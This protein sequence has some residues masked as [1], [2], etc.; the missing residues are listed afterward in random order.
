M[1]KTMMTL[2]FFAAVCGNVWA[3][4]KEVKVVK[5]N[6]TTSLASALGDDRYNIDSLV[7]KGIISSNDFL[8]LRDCCENGR[9]TGVN[10]GLCS[11]SQIPECAFRPS[12]VNGVS[13]K[14]AVSAQ[15]GLQYITLPFNCRSIGTEAFAM[16]ELRQVELNAKIKTVG[17]GAF[18]NCKE[19]KEVVVR[20]RENPPAL[21]NAPFEGVGAGCTF[22][23]PEG[24][25]AVYLQTPGWSSLSG[26]T[27]D[28]R[29]YRIKTVDVDGTSLSSLL[30]DDNN[31]TDSLV[32]TG[33]LHPEDFQTLWEN[34]VYG[35]LT[36]INLGGCEVEGGKI[37]VSAFSKE[38]ED[39]Y[40][41][42]ASSLRYITLPDDITEIGAWAFRK[43]DNLHAF[44]FPS[45]LE[46]IGAEAFLGCTQLKEIHLPEGFKSVGK[47]TFYWCFRVTDMSLPST[48]DTVDEQSLSL[49]DEFASVSYPSCTIRFNRMVPPFFLPQDDGVGL[50]SSISAEAFGALKDWKLYVPVGAKA[51]FEA[52]EH[53]GQ[54]PEII[55]TPELTGVTASVKGVVDRS[56]LGGMTEVYTPSGRLVAKGDGLPVLPKG[57]YIVKTGGQTRKVVL[58]N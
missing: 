32:V 49:C 26:L 30:G 25:K 44:R 6:S 21:E 8:V 10:L 54:I 1:N 45:R 3:Q 37:P 33:R 14:R 39:G 19:L 48:L 31:R 22:Y 50:L 38:D 41:R 2:A 18:R 15:T 23:I 20:S 36:G 16:T 24:S 56:V 40:Y 58:G 7:V 43:N 57:L 52:D 5:L 51:V 27:E 46:R 29:A 34:C 55:E 13:G 28:A 53:W 42:P 4:Q 47:N 9:L 35:V 12:K 11:A 17:D